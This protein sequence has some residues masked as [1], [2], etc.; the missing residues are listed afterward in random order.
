MKFLAALIAGAI[1]TTALAQE[2]TF[3]CR[4]TD[5]GRLDQAAT[6]EVETD[7]PILQVFGTITENGVMFTALDSGDGTGL[8]IGAGTFFLAQGDVTTEDG[9]MSWA[10]G[11]IVEYDAR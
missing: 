4:I 7:G 2:G 6:C 8:L 9:S 10:N 11:Y 1:G 3:P 5:G